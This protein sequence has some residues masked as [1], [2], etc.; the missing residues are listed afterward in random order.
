MGGGGGKMNPVRVVAFLL[1]FG[2]RVIGLIHHI[3]T[4]RFLTHLTV[5]CTV[6]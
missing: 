5:D 1:I 2:N 4:G 6:C 3:Q